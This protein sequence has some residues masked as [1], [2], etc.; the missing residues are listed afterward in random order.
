MSKEQR[1]GQEPDPRHDLYSLGVMWYQLLVGDVTRELHPGWAEELVE[2]QGVGVAQVEMIKQCV[3]LLKRRPENGS[4]LLERLHCLAGAGASLQPDTAEVQRVPPQRE[5]PLVGSKAEALREEVMGA[6]L[7]VGKLPRGSNWRM[8]AVA[9]FGIPT[10]CFAPMGLMAFQELA[11]KRP[12]RNI[13]AGTNL[14]LAVV[15]GELLFAALALASV[16][17]L[18]RLVR[19]HRKRTREV[20]LR[21][22]DSAK[23]TLS[24]AVITFDPEDSK[25]L[26]RAGLQLAS[27]IQKRHLARNTSAQIRCPG[28]E[29]VGQGWNYM[30]VLDCELLGHGTLQ[31]G[32]D[33]PAKLCRGRHY[34]ELDRGSD[35]IGGWWFDIPHDGNCKVDLRGPFSRGVV[36]FWTEW[37]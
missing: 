8:I 9:F 3:G 37:R 23:N 17:S 6:V 14:L 15:S 34:L 4:K 18:W 31:D 7:E 12:P 10:I 29:F 24:L 1:D 26:C 35:K 20:L 21:A 5:T 2:E 13:D 30:V 16:W 19:W 32:F 36:V 25:S 28:M 22:I 33:L 27:D 11:L